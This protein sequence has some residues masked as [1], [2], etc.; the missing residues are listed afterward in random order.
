MFI[1]EVNI[2]VIAGN[3]GDGCVSFQR[4]KYKSRGPADGGDG[5]R[6]GSIF[7]VGDS[8]YRTL[9]SFRYKK[10]YKAASGKQGEKNHR[11]GASGS[12][13][14]LKAPLGTIAYEGNSLIGEILTEGQRLLLAEGGIGGKGNYRFA[15]SRRRSPSFAQKGEPGEI[16]EIKL[17]LKLL[18]DVGLIGYPNVGKS[19]LV[20][21]ISSAKPKIA[22]YPFTTLHPTLGMVENDEQ[23]SFVV[24]DIPGIIEGAHQG[25]GLGDKFLR[26]IERTATIVIVIDLAASEL[27]PLLAWKKV[28]KEL[29]AYDER[30]LDRHQLTVGNKIDLP[31]AKQHLGKVE[32]FFRDKGITFLP[33]SAITHQGLKK[34]VQVLGDFVEKN[35][36]VP[37]ETITQKPIMKVYQ[38]WDDPNQVRVQK[39]GK[40]KWRL[41]GKNVVRLILMTDFGNQQAVDYLRV[42][43]ARLG[44]DEILIEAGVKE[45]DEIDVGSKIFEFKP[46]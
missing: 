18:A 31:I 10:T 6:G 32:Q 44:V 26:H 21:A 27:D 23:Q 4:R 2:K 42:Q 35:K 39:I 9:Q 38:T 13:L 3:G 45:G 43:L 28:V 14:F 15:N 17:E 40:N 1:D 34:F 37:A 33:V 16:R 12:D 41:I 46:S 29:A 11:S 20:A 7:L 19:S 24:A 30:L 22:N 5:G 36:Q 25:R 8:G